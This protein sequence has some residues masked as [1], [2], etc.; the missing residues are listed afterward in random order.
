MRQDNK[1]QGVRNGAD[2]P[3]DGG[4]RRTPAANLDAGMH[5]DAIIGTRSGEIISYEFHRSQVRTMF[6]N[7]AVWFVAV[8][9]CR[10]LDLANPRQVLS[11]L[12]DDERS[13]ASV[14]TGKV[15]RRVATVNESG[16]FALILTSRKPEA[17]AFRRW[18]TGEVIPS[19]RKTGQ[20][21][22]PEANQQK[23]IEND[24]R[25]EA[26]DH[27]VYVVIVSHARHSVRKVDCEQVFAEFDYHL[28]EILAHSVLT[29]VGSVE[30]AK[31]RN[32]VHLDQGIA[33]EWL[34]QNL[35][36][37]A[38][39]ARRFLWCAQEQR[40]RQAEKPILPS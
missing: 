2:D 39:V 26:K 29:M 21:C 17:K 24:I 1:G 7:G 25:I 18:I 38:D 40:H 15:T 32:S 19:I 13:Y 5:D 35:K 12:D 30:V 23:T 14:Q 4:Q 33:A 8:D 11:R 3:A 27:G 31:M 22:A 37:A 34:D 28:A 36:Q 10:V 20:Y 9:V 6:Q 16:L